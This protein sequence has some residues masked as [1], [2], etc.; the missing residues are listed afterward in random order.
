MLEDDKKNTLS[1]QRRTRTGQIQKHRKSSLVHAVGRHHRPKFA[2]M[3]EESV[4]LSPTKEVAFFDA[5]K[6]CHVTVDSLT[7]TSP[8]PKGKTKRARGKQSTPYKE[9]LRTSSAILF[10][11][12][13]PCKTN[14][15]I[16]S[17][18]I[19]FAGEASIGPETFSQKFP[20]LCEK[21]DHFSFSVSKDE[22]CANLQRKRSCS[23][24]Q[25]IG[26]S[27]KDIFQELGA[28]IIEKTHG[29]FY[30]LAHRKG[31]ALG[32]EQVPENLDPATAG[33][34]Y[35][36]LFY[37]ENPL[38]DL[39]LHEDI[40][41]ALVEGVVRYHKT[42]LLPEAITY[43]IKWGNGKEYVKTIHPLSYRTPSVDENLLAKEMMKLTK[44]PPKTEERE[45]IFQSKEKR[46]IGFWKE[47][48]PEPM[49]T[50]TI[51]L[52]SQ[53]TEMSDESTNKTGL[54]RRSLF[55]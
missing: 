11:E 6:H 52:D 48:C 30:H 20:N 51:L 18:S 19:E 49:D 21:K 25:V 10:M 17:G 29:S 55:A 2:L 54:V 28:V 8:S 7:M 26:F 14:S 47:T 43:T 45:K 12:E 24:Q 46:D 41:S 44:T 16:P 5:V 35:T 4:L 40:E 37:I 53:N 39:I 27:A 32:G 36:T 23:Q 1:V 38:I 3:R 34:N 9:T 50:G 33:S 42:L 13:S 22:L 31:F 15:A